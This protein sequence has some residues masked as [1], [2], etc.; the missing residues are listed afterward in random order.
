MKP[1]RDYNH[2]HALEGYLSLRQTLGALIEIYQENREETLTNWP[3]LQVG[4]SRKHNFYLFLQLCNQTYSRFIYLSE[5]HFI[6]N[7]ER[8]LQRFHPNTVERKITIN[9]SQRNTQ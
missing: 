6:E 4:K 3:T 9:P 5:S 7:I 2:F 8:H 1:H